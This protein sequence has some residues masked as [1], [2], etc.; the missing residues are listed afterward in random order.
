MKQKKVLL[1]VAEFTATTAVF[2]SGLRA[3]TR[4][5]SRGSVSDASVSLLSV[6]LPPTVPPESLRPLYCSWDSRRHIL[7]MEMMGKMISTDA[8]IMTADAFTLYEWQARSM[9]VTSYS[10]PRLIMFNRKANSSCRVRPINSHDVH[11]E[12][13]EKITCERANDSWNTDKCIKKEDMNPLEV[14]QVKEVGHGLYVF[15]NGHMI[16]INDTTVPCPTN[17]FVVPSNTLFEING[18]HYESRATPQAALLTPELL[19]AWQQSINA[20]LVPG[21]NPYEVH[22]NSESVA[23]EIDRMQ[24]LNRHQTWT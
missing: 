9:C 23:R 14:I 3:F 20:H 2:A 12:A 22:T 7:M 19:S 5:W 21:A 6:P 16:R 13:S 8:V 18:M 10:G 15:C 11:L 1:S 24:R 17:V 4:D